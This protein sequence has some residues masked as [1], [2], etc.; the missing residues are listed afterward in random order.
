MAAFVVFGAAPSTATV[1]PEHPH[2][3]GV[4]A[5]ELEVQGASP[6]QAARTGKRLPAAGQSRIP[7]D[8]D[9]Q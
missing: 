5:I 6:A 4:V 3:E 2:V 8:A 1:F 9:L 7:G